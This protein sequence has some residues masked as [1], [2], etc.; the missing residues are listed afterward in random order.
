MASFLKTAKIWIRNPKH[1]IAYLPRGEYEW[2]EDEHS[3]IKKK[4][5]NLI[6]STLNTKNQNLI[7]Q[8]AFDS[9]KVRS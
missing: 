5:I 3:S 8:E 6:Q 2:S 7:F 1:T 9:K 4:S